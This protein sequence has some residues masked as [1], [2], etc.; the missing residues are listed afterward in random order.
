LLA[1]ETVTFTTRVSCNT[2]ALLVCE[3]V[4]SKTQI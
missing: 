1:C 3:L 2:F 4:T